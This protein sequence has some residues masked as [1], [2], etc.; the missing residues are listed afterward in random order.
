MAYN[1]VEVNGET[2]IDL[3][4]DTVTADTLVSGRTAHLASGEKVTGTF[5]PVTQEQ[6]D[7][8]STYTGYSTS[9]C[10]IYCNFDTKETKRLGAAAGL[11]AGSDFD[12]FPLFGGRKRCNVSADGTI[13]AYYGDSNFT[14]DGS[15]GDVMV[16]QPKFYY[17]FIP[18]RLEA[19][20]N[21]EG[22]HIREGEWWVSSTQESGFKLHPLFKDENGYEIDYVLLSAYEASLYDT[23]AGAYI[24][25][26]AQVADFNADTVGSIANSKPISGL[27]QNLTRANFEKLAKNKGA[28]WHC[29]TIQSSMAQVMLMAI[30]FGQFDIQSALGLGVVN[31]TDDSTKNCASLTGSTSSLGNASGQAASTIDYT[32]TTQTENGKT[33]VSYRGLENPY[34]NIWKFEEGL[35]VYGNGSQRYGVPYICDDYSFEENTFDGY[36]GAGFTIAG[37][38]YIKAF[39]Y[40]NA[41]MDWLFAASDVTAQANSV[42]GDYA[43]GTA[44]LIGYRMARLGA[45]WDSGLRAGP[46]CLHVN[47]APSSRVRDLGGRNIYIPQSRQSKDLDKTIKRDENNNVNYTQDTINNFTISAANNAGLVGYN[48]VNIG[49]LNRAKVGAGTAE[50]PG[51]IEMSVTN[52]SDSNAIII[53]EDTSGNCITIDKDDIGINAGSIHFNGITIPYA[54]NAGFHNSIYRGKYLGNTYTA[55]QKAQVQAG[56]FDDLFM[57]DYWAINN[58]NWRIAHFDYYLNTGDTA[59]TKHHLVIVP[60]TPLTISYMNSTNITTGAYVGSYMFTTTLLQD[61]TEASDSVFGK[62]KAAFGESNLLSIRQLFANAV[63]SN[64][65]VSGWTWYSTRCF[66]MNQCMVYGHKAWANGNNDGYNVGIDKTQLALFAHNPTS[67]NTRQTYWLRDVRSSASFANVVNNGRADAYGASDVVGVRPV[68]L[69]S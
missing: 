43:W 37:G 10:G 18:I 5:E 27:S 48:Q 8:L 41:D 11:T 66:L 63:D 20:T 46:F 61:G 64:G 54:N 6:I 14:E 53:Q 3:T 25:D 26:D 31:I 69:L 49:G 15:N 28:G 65:N 13:T 34:G 29:D 1:K 9:A 7:A 42:V 21:S 59:T 19:I 35:A 67:I 62:I 50:N 39:G 12:K 36:T 58:I 38:N 40:G 57:G 60:D 55:A 17:K 23:S 30:E 2:L 44:N 68:V 51:T 24:T 22:Y 47:A 45:G 52:D 16:Y 4:S 33:A 56:T 32:G